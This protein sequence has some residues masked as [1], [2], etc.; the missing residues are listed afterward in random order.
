P[1]SYRDRAAVFPHIVLDEPNQPSPDHLRRPR[2][3]V[4]AG[5]LLPWKGVSLALRA[6]SLSPGW[7]LTICGDGPD[8]ARLQRL[9]GKLGLSDRVTFAGWLPRQQLRSVLGSSEVFLF[10]S[11][12]DEGG[13]VV[14]EALQAGA[15]VI[16]LDIGGPPELVSGS[17]VVVAA[18]GSMEDIAQRLASALDRARPGTQTN[19][20]DRFLIDNRT[21]ELHLLL[22]ARFPEL[23]ATRTPQMIPEEAAGG[24]AQL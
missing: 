15:A 9:A 8:R 6:I 13:W 4:F 20:A 10:P 21:E 24:R 1:G 16:C 17:G 11:L 2:T 23:F 12:H 7:H 14:T 5:R 22:E 18:S 19:G 3:A